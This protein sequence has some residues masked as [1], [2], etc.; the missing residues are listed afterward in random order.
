MEKLEIS[1]KE[2]NE[3]INKYNC[4]IS[5]RKIE[6]EYPYSF[7]FIQKLIKSNNWRNQIK[8]NYPQKN[9]YL[10]IAVCKKT[11]KVFNDY[12]NES[13]AITKHVVQLYPIE[14]NIS[15]YIRKSKEY[16]TGK[17][18]YDDYF[19][20]KY[21]KIVETKK[22]LYCDWTT[23]DVDN[24]SGA[25]EK[26][27]LNIHNKTV[28][29][30]L[31][32]HSADRD[33]FKQK[34]LN[35][36]HDYVICK[37]CN[38]KLMILN[39]KHLK[40]HNI[41]VYDYKMKYDEN[42]VSLTTH[43]KLVN[44]TKITNSKMVKSKTSKAENEIKQFLID[45]GI[46]VLQ[47][48]RKYLNGIEIDLLSLEHKI[49]IE[50]D[51]N[52]YHTENYG[53]KMH[54]YHLNKTNLAN[55]NG[56]DLYHIFEDEWENQKEIIKNKLLHLFN[57]SNSMIIGARK[58]EISVISQDIKSEF[59]LKNHIQGND[60]SKIRLGAFYNDEL[61]AVMTFSNLRNM[62]K[63]KNYDQNTYE[64]TRFVIKNNYII[65][66][67]A[68]RLLKFFIQNYRPDRIISFADRR[69]T[70][71]KE[72]N[73]YTKLGFK[74]IQIL[75]PDYSYYNMKLHRSKRLH[76]FGFG[77]GNL[78]RRYPE[79]YDPNKTEWEMMQELGYDRIWDCGKFKYEL[80]IP[81][82]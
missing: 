53:G 1:E 79:T 65:T 18:W 75:K 10:M 52:L 82:Q 40:K 68:D 45:N 43:N 81:L 55:N 31:K 78:K 13:G 63:E 36:P 14:G 4:G 77:K 74:C 30:H 21:E 6:Q 19:I 28:N 20:F 50:Y 42:I 56:I 46:N 7:T 44:S 62:S 32:K 34:E 70:P 22:C 29:D 61:C 35:N 9:D 39:D 60:K 57:K 66:G 71:N 51:G 73:L 54:G 27:L 26:H 38:K 47:S 80:I 5:M 64:L 69:W 49:G 8:L 41:S 23:N 72:H 37:I 16:E 11:N 17:F 67:I 59:L 76:K 58:C 25:Y 24:L 2:R 12:S 48:T 15:K 3:I 33:Y